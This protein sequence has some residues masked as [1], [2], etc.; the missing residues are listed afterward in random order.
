MILIYYTFIYTLK[1]KDVNVMLSTTLSCRIREVRKNKG[2]TQE[3]LAEKTDI[4]ESYIG[5]IER[6]VYSNFT[7]ET[8]DKL[9]NGLDMSYSDFFQFDVCNKG[10]HTLDHL[11]SQSDR[12]EELVNLLVKIV[13]F[14]L[15]KNSN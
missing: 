8:L 4:D 1:F 6:G 15:D 2:Y 11:I 14:E 7:I 13:E 12:K 3:K 10:I 5:K 9:I